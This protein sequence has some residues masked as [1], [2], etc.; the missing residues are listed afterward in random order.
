MFIPMFSFEKAHLNSIRKENCKNPIPLINPSPEIKMLR[1][2]NVIPY[3]FLPKTNDTLNASMIRN[4]GMKLKD[5]K[6]TIFNIV[7]SGRIVWSKLNYL[8]KYIEHHKLPKLISMFT[9]K[10]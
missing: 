6:K 1:R 9:N 10:A 4:V 2:K 8:G 7:A 5:L 3:L